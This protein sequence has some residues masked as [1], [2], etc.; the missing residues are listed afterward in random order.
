MLEL[1]A[2]QKNPLFAIQC[3]LKGF[4]WLMR[5]ELR[6]YFL[7]PLLV[8]ILLY[9]GLFALGY[10][11]LTDLINS[12]IPDWLSWLEWLL[13]PLF[14]ISFLVTGFFT[15]TLVANLIASPF[16][17]HLAARTEELLSG[18]KVDIEEQPMLKVLLAETKRIGY[19]LSRMLPLLLLFVIPLVNLIAPLLW[20]LF[21]AW[22]CALEYMAYPLE[23]KGLLFR[24]QRQLLQQS[25][26]SVLTFGGVVVLGITVPIV[27]L[28]MAP[29]AVIA[30]TVFFYSANNVDNK[31]QAS[32]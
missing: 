32:K 14:L 27:N 15:F 8:N 4:Q 26:L 7:L 23:N 20:A 12:L 19:L 10:F 18:D 25:R 2:Q 5:K 29:A 3:L 16:Y 31:K 28:L 6:K 17:N 13:W 1:T 9:S 22:G 21:G 30:A 11:Y 24:E